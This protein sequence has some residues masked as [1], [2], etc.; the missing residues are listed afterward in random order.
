MRILFF[1]ASLGIVAAENGLDGW[2]RYASLSCTGQCRSKL[3]ANIVVLNATETSPIYIA[4]SELQIGLK[5]IYGSHAEITWGKCKASSSVVVGTVEQYRETCGSLSGIPELE[6]DG[7][8]LSTQGDKVRILGSNDRGALYGAFEYLSML[9]QGNFSAVAYASNPS[10]PIRWVNQ[11][12][13][14]DGSI[15]RG[16]GGPSI[17]FKDGA[18]VEDLSRVKQYGRL[19]ASVR[20]NAVVINNVN[21]NATLLTPENLKGLG[22]IADVF[23]P[24]GVKIGISLNF[25]SPETLGGL[26]TYDPLDTS[27]IDW[28]SSVTEQLY[29]NV[30]DMAGYLVKADSEGEP[31]PAVYNRTLSQGA[32]LFAKALQPYGGIVMFRAF[33]YNQ[34]NESNWDADRAKAA[35]DFFKPLDGE[36]EE[37]VVVQIKFGPID[38]QVREPTSPLFANLFNTSSAIELEVTQEYLGQQSHL[39]YLP[40]LWKTVLDF[41]LRVD[42]KPS[43][44]RDIITGKRFN[45]KLGG[46]AAVVNVGTNTTWLGSH[47]SMSNLY[48]YGRLAWNAADDP[49]AILQD[50][51]RLTFGLDPTVLKTLTQLSM[52]SWPAYENYSGNLG[53]Q[54]LTDILYTHYGPNPQSQDGNGWGQW[55]RAD[56][57][58]IGMDRTVSNGTGYSGQ[59]PDEIAAIY[60]DISTTPDD[61][62]LWFHHVNYTHR[63]HSGKTII[64]HFYD[65]HYSGAESAQSFLTQWESLKGK[66]DEERYNHIRHRLDYQ[67]GHSIV[68]RD[69]INNF[70]HNLSGIPDTSKRVGHHPWRIEAE[71]MNLDGYKVYTVSPFETASG[72]I[73]IVTASNDTVGT[74]TTKVDFPSGTYDLA[75]NY[76]DLYGGKSH[77]ELYLNNHQIGEWAGNSED[78][79][80]H[81]PSIYL[82]GHSAMRIKFRGVM[83]QKGDVLKIVGKPDGVEPAPLDYVAFLPQGVV[84]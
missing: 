59:Y 56:S 31:G 58:S 19:L 5:S 84:D 48:G 50:W 11:W 46:S 20:I 74:A 9:A 64:Q 47:L 70:Y 43:L 76:Y 3:P 41:D 21:A 75:V 25:A 71:N 37:N 7:F 68:W 10:A 36:F 72:S 27:V 35:V 8:W 80:S 29:Q 57:T 69:A 42:H 26:D 34:L 78:V 17:F 55:T 30:P 82:D 66:V 61:L 4:G 6:E 44:V 62:L 79:L 63:L 12:D 16:Y 39:V 14:M 67:T 15:E 77:W 24:Y 40:P 52:E 65:A 18:I 73:A 51:I 22:R 60:E 54:T 81:T 32:N 28:W 2:L 83:V 23:R 38:F 13:N 33:V 45:R 53:I 49:E 1:L